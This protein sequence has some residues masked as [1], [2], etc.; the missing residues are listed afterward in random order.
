MPKSLQ[1]NGRLGGSLINK[2]RI[3]VSV[4]SIICAVVV[5]FFAGS[6][7]AW[8]VFGLDVAIG[9]GDSTGSRADWLAAMGTWAVGIAAVLYARGER[10]QNK[11]ENRLANKKRLH[12]NRGRTRLLTVKIGLLRDPLQRYKKFFSKR[13]QTFGGLMGLVDGSIQAVSIVQFTDEERFLFTEKNISDLY[14]LEL[15][16]QRY[17]H[18]ASK[19]KDNDYKWS[20]KLVFR[21]T[22]YLHVSIRTA[23]ELNKRAMTVLSV[24]ERFRSTDDFD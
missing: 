18:V 9:F 21:K 12:E 23:R 15:A 10:L 22:Q 20:A 2:N 16:A 4:A 6:I 3:Q 14:L 8:F 11:R 17:L 1:W 5:V 7:S 19:I 13:D 24:V